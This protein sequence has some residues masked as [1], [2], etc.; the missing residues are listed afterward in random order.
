[1]IGERERGKVATPWIQHMA[2]EEDIKSFLSRK[3]IAVVGASRDKSK[4]GNIA[5]QTLKSLG[6]RVFP[7]NPN[8]KSVA[9][10]DC[11]PNLRSIPERIEAVLIVV[12]PENTE[13]IIREA[14][15]VGVHHIWMQPGAES[16]TA[17]RF[18][19]EKKLCAVYNS[20]ILIQTMHIQNQDG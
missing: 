11:Y 7:V 9:G 3:S 16:E 2:A 1:M 5:Y 15:E 17:I 4:Y 19:E 8:A 6:Y 10:D 12:Q 13:E 14:A 20:C 18:C